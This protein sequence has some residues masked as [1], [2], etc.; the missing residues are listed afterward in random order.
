[1]RRAANRHRRTD[2]LISAGAGLFVIHF[3]LYIVRDERTVR[4]VHRRGRRLEAPLDGNKNFPHQRD[5]A[6]R[7]TFNICKAFVTFPSSVTED[8][9][10]SCLSPR[11]RRAN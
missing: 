9:L 11:L 7:P 2:P 8:K 5:G 6:K 3:A 1:M 4:T 10:Q